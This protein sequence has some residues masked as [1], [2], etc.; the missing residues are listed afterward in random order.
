I[1]RGI[2]LAC[3]STII[4]GAGQSSSFTVVP[5]AFRELG[6]AETY[7]GMIFGVPSAIAIFAA[8][9]LGRKSDILGRRRILGLS[10]T[11]YAFATLAFGISLHRFVDSRPAAAIV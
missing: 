8:P 9:A 11:A 2:I 1:N 10:L 4:F 3:L 6:L 5:I 7:A